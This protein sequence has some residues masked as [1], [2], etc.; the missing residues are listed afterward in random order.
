MK[1]VTNIK[2]L[3]RIS[4][5]VTLDQSKNII[6]DLKMLLI[7]LDRNNETFALSAIQIGI[8]KRIIVFS[9]RH[10]G[11]VLINPK[12]ISSGE[13]EVYG[14]EGCMSLPK[15]IVRNISIKRAKKVKVRFMDENGNNVVSKFYGINARALQH[16][17]DHLNGILIIDR[18]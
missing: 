1:I 11:E 15:T 12:I 17:V 18:K 14:L 4:D 10:G 8:T 7:R 16:E 5:P 13:K 9:K 3:R 2:K 6:K